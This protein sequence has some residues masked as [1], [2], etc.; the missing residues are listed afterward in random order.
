MLQNSELTDGIVENIRVGLLCCA[1]FTDDDSWYRARIID[2]IETTETQ[3]AQVVYIDFGNKE[4]VPKGRL[5]RLKKQHAD[6]PMMSVKCSLDGVE[7]VI[8]V[9]FALKYT[10]RSY[11]FFLAETAS[12]NTLCMFYE[13]KHLPCSCLSQV[14]GKCKKV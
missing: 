13:L 9:C 10:N 12:P 6:T 8:A 5:R 14:E 11:D 4:Y 2:C 1:Q 7:S 3:T